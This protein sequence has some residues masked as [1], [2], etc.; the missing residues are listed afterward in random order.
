MKAGDYMIHIYL[1]HGKGFKLEENHDDSDGDNIKTFNAML[2]FN[3][4]DEKKYST[5]LKDCPVNT[6]D[7]NY[8]GEHFFFEPKG[9]TE[10][11]IQELTLEIKVLD[12]GFFRD[13]CIGQFDIDISKIYLAND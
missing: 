1:Q 10:D 12:K 6:D 8:W 11:D 3:L 2:Q 13:K 5:P 7:P 4:G 9:M